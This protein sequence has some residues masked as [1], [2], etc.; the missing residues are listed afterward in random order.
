MIQSSWFFKTSEKKSL[1][2][3]KF[4]ALELIYTA[5]KNI[6]FTSNTSFFKNIESK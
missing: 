6:I 1:I 2:P 4:I 5:K 3:Q